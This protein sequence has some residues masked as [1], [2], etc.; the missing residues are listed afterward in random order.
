MDL[1]PMVTR[2]RA[3]LDGADTVVVRNGT[4]VQVATRVV[5]SGQQI[6]YLATGWSLETLA[7]AV[8]EETIRLALIV[9]GCVLA[10]VFLIQAVMAGR[11]VSR[12]IQR[13]TGVMKQLAGGNQIGRAHV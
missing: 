1:Q 10:I 3:R 7:Q 8:R 4:Q 6:G 13:I 5:L 11:Y 12:P 2:E 9:G